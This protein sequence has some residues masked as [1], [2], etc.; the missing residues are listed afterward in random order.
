MRTSFWNSASTFWCMSGVDACRKGHY[1]S[2]SFLQAFL[3]PCMHGLHCQYRH[4]L[5]V[6]IEH[7]LLLITELKTHI[8]G[9]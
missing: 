1:L 7:C 6:L 3:N 4:L 5:D 9:G 2:Q 8:A